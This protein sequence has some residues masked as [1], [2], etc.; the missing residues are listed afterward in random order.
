[1]TYKAFLLEQVNANREPGWKL[2]E[3]DAFPSRDMPPHEAAKCAALQGEEAFGEYHLRLHRAKHREKRDITN[4]LVLWDIAREAGL[5]AERFAEDLKSGATRPLIGQEHTEAVEEYGVFGVP[6]LL[7]DGQEPTFLKLA[8]GDWEG[9]DD[10]E[11]F[12]LVSTLSARRPYVLELKKPE[13]ARLAER[14][15]AKYRLRQGR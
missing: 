2:W 13:S 6:T 1:M 3:D 9:K 15:A 5:D 8:E 12:D 4:Q 11:L 14:A 7:F 10:G